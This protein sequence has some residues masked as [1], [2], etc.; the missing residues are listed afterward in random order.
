MIILKL[1]TSGIIAWIRQSA[2]TL[3]LKRW[4][5]QHRLKRKKTFR[6]AIPF[7]SQM[8]QPRQIAPEAP[9]VQQTLRL[10][11]LKL[12][13]LQKWAIEG[14]GLTASARVRDSD[15]RIA[16]VKNSWKDGWSLPGGGVEPNETPSEAAQREVREETGLSATIGEPLVVLDQTYVSEDDGEE[17]FS[18]L[19]VV[20]SASADGDISDA[21]QLGVT[22]DEISAARWFDTIPEE[23]H[24]GELLR[25]YL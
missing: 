20:Y 10:P 4:M 9:R 25:P 17:W 15:G 23:L 6:K 11:V 7:L 1:G 3:F 8:P 21:S 2:G 5:T 18:A 16:L 14:T 24:D 19:F 22:D 13:S 12:E